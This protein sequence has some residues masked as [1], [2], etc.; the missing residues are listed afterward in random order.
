LGRAGIE[1]A[2][3]GF[4]VQWKPHFSPRKCTF[5]CIYIPWNTPRYKIT[6]VATQVAAVRENIR[7]SVAPFILEANGEADDGSHD[8]QYSQ[9]FLGDNMVKR[10]V[11]DVSDVALAGEELLE[12]LPIS[13]V[14]G[15]ILPIAAGS[16]NF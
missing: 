2:T 14:R 11:G 6:C 8:L 12:L 13:E 9:G 4:S 1:P 16:G 7:P 10:L 5:D 3:H 15:C